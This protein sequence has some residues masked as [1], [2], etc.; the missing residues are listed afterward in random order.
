MTEQS[1]PSQRSMEIARASYQAMFDADAPK[2]SAAIRRA[3]RVIDAE[4]RKGEELARA[5]E[6]L[7]A[8]AQGLSLG[9]DWNKGTAAGYHRQS[10]L[11]AIPAAQA[12][13]AAYRAST[14]GQP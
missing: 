5:V 3:A 12:A 11:D 4:L 7:V 13:L 10:L 14:G 1:E 2:M 8:A 6:P 9:T